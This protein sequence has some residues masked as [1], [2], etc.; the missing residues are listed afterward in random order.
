MKSP[1][2]PKIL[3]PCLVYHYKYTFGSKG[4]FVIKINSID[5]L[6]KTY[7]CNFLT[8]NQICTLL[9]RIDL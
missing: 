2:L 7:V 8:V 5:T 9:L 1:T 4:M 3:Y 6:S